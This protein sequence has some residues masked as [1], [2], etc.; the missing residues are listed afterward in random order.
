MPIWLI[1]VIVLLVVIVL[2]FITTKNSLVRAKNRVKEEYSHIDVV[3]K[4]RFDLI[5]NLV[6]TVKGY[7]KHE[8]ET[9]ENII[10]AR[11]KYLAA[12]NPSDAIEANNGLTSGLTKLFALAESYPELKSNTNFQELQKELSKTEDQVANARTAYNSAVTHFN[13]LVEMFPSSIVASMSGYE[14]EKFF[15]APEEEKKNPEIKF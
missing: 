9:L 4:R 12:G 8:K 10:E 7:A 6:E 5:P 11:N 15:E 1:V 3:L 2:Y 14:K 13:N